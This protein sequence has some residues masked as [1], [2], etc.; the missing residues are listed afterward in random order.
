M[1]KSR[2]M[3]GEG[4]AQL[5]AQDWGSLETC[6]CNGVSIRNNSLET[7]DWVK[8]WKVFP[9]ELGLWISNIFR[10]TQAVDNTLKH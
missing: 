8:L 6:L 3:T 7:K 10:A 2:Q 5:F 9:K 1:H 4:G